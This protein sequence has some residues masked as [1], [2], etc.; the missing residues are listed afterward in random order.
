M[1]SFNMGGTAETVYSVPEYESI[2]GLFLFPGSF[3]YL[4]HIGL[5]KSQRK[6]ESL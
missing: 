4:D 6:G 5:C 3:V 1:V 2:L